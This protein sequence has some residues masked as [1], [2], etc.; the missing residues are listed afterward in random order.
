MRSLTRAE[1]AGTGAASPSGAL[2]EVHSFGLQAG[3]APS[4]GSR[5]RSPLKTEAATV[6]SVRRSSASAGRGGG[7]RTVRR[8]RGST[9]GATLFTAS[10]RASSPRIRITGSSSSSFPPS[11][12]RPQKKRLLLGRLQ[13]SRRACSCSRQ[14]GG[15]SEAIATTSR[16][17][18][19]QGPATSGRHRA[20]TRTKRVASTS[21]T[22]MKTG[23]PLLLRPRATGGPP[24]VCIRVRTSRLR[25]GT[26]V[27]P[28]ISSCRETGQSRGASP[29]GSRQ[30]ARF[31]RPGKYQRLRPRAGSRVH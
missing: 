24:A 7:R 28:S 10:T 22:P 4:P 26:C 11:L 6:P 21:Q 23:S 12:P 31:G 8:S 16:P 18:Q 17:R 9:P 29:A 30:E 2:G 14:A 20:E 1:P 13:P 25:S 19:E 5:T 15:R 3:P 27:R